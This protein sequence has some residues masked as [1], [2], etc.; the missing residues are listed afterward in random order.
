MTKRILSILLV[1]AL[2]GGAM[3]TAPATTRASTAS[4]TASPNTAAAAN[5]AV[6]IYL[7]T[8]ISATSYI[9]GFPSA[10]TVPSSISA[11]AVTI[12]GVA[13][14][15]VSVNSYQVA[16]VPAATVLA[17]SYSI[18]FSSACG[19]TNPSNTGS[20]NFSIST[21]GATSDVTTAYATIGG[22]GSGS[23]TITPSSTAAS[24]TGVAL[25]VGFTPTYSVSF[26]SLN[27]SGYTFLGTPSLSNVYITGGSGLLTAVSGSGSMLYLTF[28]TALTAYSS[29]TLYIT[30]GCNLMNPTTANTYS[31]TATLSGGGPQTLTGTVAIGGGGSGGLT[32]TPSSTAAS[33]TGVAL[34]V[35]FTPTYS[36]SFISLNLSGYTFLGTPSLSNVYIT[37]GSGLL[38]AV[39]GSGSMLYL[40]FGTA[41]TAYSSYTLYITSGCNLMNPTTANTYSITATLSGGGPQTLTG[42]VA[43]GGTGGSITNL[44]LTVYPLLPGTAAQYYVSFTTSATGTLLSGDY[45]YIIFPS[46]TQFPTTYNSGQ[47]LVNNVACTGALSVSG[48]TLSIPV[49]SSLTYAQTYISV[50][51]YSGFGIDNPTTNGYYNLQVSTSKDTTAVTSNSYQIYGTTISGLTVQ[52]DPRSRGAN[53]RI[54]LSFLTSGSGYLTAGSDTIV[55][56]FS[57]NVTMPPVYE[58]SYVTVNGTQASGV[59]L[60]STGKL[61]I[62]TPVTISNNQQVTLV[63]A[64]EFGITNPSTAS[65]TVTIQVSTSK[66][67]SAV[68][69]SYTTTTSQVAQPQVTL[70]TNGVGKAS[71]Y[72]VTFQTGA[73]GTL[74]AGSGRIYLTFPAGTSV[75]ASIDA[76]NVKVNGTTASI[77][78]SSTGNRRV[79]VTTPVAILANSQVQVVIDVAANIMNPPTARTDYTLS[80]YTTAEQTP[81][82]SSLYS[83]VNLPTTTAVTSPS[84]PDGLNGY[85]RTRPTVSLTATSPSGLAVSIYYRINAGSDTQ[86]S[87]PVQ[88]PE[89]SVA[90]SY[91]ARDTQGNQE[92]ARQLTFKV[93][94]TAPLITITAPLEGSATGSADIAVTGRT[95]AGASVV[96]NSIPATTQPTGDFTASVTLHEGSN[97]IQV[98]A[99]DIAG[100]VGQTRV[101][102]TLDTKPPVLTT[103]SPKIYSTVMTQQVTVS[104]KTEAGATVMV[105]G[106]KVNVAAD[107]SFSILYMF[108]KEGLNVIEVSSTDAA[109]NVAKATIPVTY[110]ARTLIRLQVGNKTAMINDTAKTLQAA[111]VNVKGVVM[112]P[113][114]FIGEAFGATVEW[115]PVFKI[116]RLQLASTTIYLQIGS[117]YASVNG[118]KIVLQGLPSIIKGTTMVPIRFISE[119]FNAQVVWNAPTQGIDITYPKP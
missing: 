110:V 98:V 27:L 32:I 80:A 101:N 56:Q 4:V 61:S 58:P 60:V 46:G 106:A 103:T 66:D 23:L 115:E 49:P 42:T 9:I 78:T 6:T 100:N 96:I 94:T 1:V 79:E 10:F 71:G 5:V 67:V 37:G 47:I 109:G 22:G 83:I 64:P 30:S 38:T 55:V 25:T 70:T 68:S 119:A 65:A 91:Y 43:I 13:A 59:T 40:T 108:P 48:T 62:T 24:A 97:A 15:S 82:T 31:I 8:A 50:Q 118:K 28:G 88:L 116:V 12:N 89:G 73:G 45:I 11:G 52:A 14:A 81:V 7:T 95:E 72:T 39:S 114:R 2:V 111:P 113:L 77:V 44:S 21:Y 18:V 76:Q 85:Y 99:T 93:D 117:N 112:V 105:G 107:G 86:Y 53:P 69:T 41:L 74:S 19:I 75:P 54:Q 33:A 51:I 34:T 26:I 84:S 16:L 36:V 104:G 17:G 63:F 3:F 87:S 102:V 20:Y 92:P 57:S 35:G 90:F 29:Y